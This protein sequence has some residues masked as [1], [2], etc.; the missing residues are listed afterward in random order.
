MHFWKH[1]VKVETSFIAPVPAALPVW[2]CMAILGLPAYGNGS[3]VAF[4]T[5]YFATRI[6]PRASRPYMPAV[7]E[8]LQHLNAET[9][10]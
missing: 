2:V 9:D 6:V 3:F 7:T 10:S 4:R 8:A 1:R 5:W